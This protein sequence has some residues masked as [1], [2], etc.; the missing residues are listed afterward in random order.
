MACWQW[1]RVASRAGVATSRL[2]DVRGIR[3]SAR[4]L[5]ARQAELRKLSLSHVRGGVSKPLFLLF[6]WERVGMACD[7]PGGCSGSKDRR[8]RVIFRWAL[9]ASESRPVPLRL[10]WT[11]WTAR[12]WN[13]D[14]DGFPLGV[15]RGL[16]GPGE[17][18]L[19]RAFRDWGRL[20]HSSG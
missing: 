3:G 6:G 18:S 8:L 12:C 5:C 20:N 9:L 11:G 14:G 1:K 7:I 10:G 2:T 4:P 17:A 19:A 15:R 16:S 13:V